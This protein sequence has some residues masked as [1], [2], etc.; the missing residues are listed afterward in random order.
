MEL[1]DIKAGLFSNPQISKSVY[2]VPTFLCTKYSEEQQNKTL[3]V[4]K[5][6]I[7]FS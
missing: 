4:L 6:T 3:P 2:L 7:S 1:R 5:D